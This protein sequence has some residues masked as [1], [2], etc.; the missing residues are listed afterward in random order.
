MAE[1]NDSKTND[2]K[3]ILL[4]LLKDP[5][6]KTAISGML[7]A[8]DEQTQI[9]E[10]EYHKL[11]NRVEKARNLLLRCGEKCITAREER[12]TARR[13]L[14]ECQKDLK[15]YIE[16][17]ETVQKECDAVRQ[18][19][20]ECLAEFDDCTEQ[21]EIVQKECREMRTCYQNAENVYQVFGKL[22]QEIREAYSN[23]LCSTSPMTLVCSAA[24]RNLLSL[25]YE[26]ITMEWNKYSDDALVALN[27]L[28][29]ALFTL[30]SE[31][32]PEYQRIITQN[33][34]A[35]DQNLHSRTSDSKPRGVI[36][37]V[38]IQGYQTD[39]SCKKSFV[40]VE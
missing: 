26:R 14:A 6:I 20:T 23:L 32:H 40:K 9:S 33:G 10:E 12:D 17:V 25:L 38:I 1:F 29:D 30:Y 35:F 2:A 4:Y 13:E 27:L 8:S 28:F 37:Q 21:L 7:C 3:Q 11:Q 36:T 24:E 18:E 16:K 19:L 39:N 22:P 5:E 31:W 15:I 34:E